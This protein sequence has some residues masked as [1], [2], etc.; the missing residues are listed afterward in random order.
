MFTINNINF[1]FPQRSKSHTAGYKEEYLEKEMVSGK[2]R[3]LYRGKRFY[4]DFFYPF[5]STAQI[6]NLKTILEYQR[7]WG[8]CNVE[9]DSAEDAFKGQAFVSVNSDQEKFET[10]IEE[11]EYQW[12]KWSLEIESVNYV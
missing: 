4:A 3:R 12:I 8:Y 11:N 9:M 2:V 5:L 10:N 1:E 6:N 7:K